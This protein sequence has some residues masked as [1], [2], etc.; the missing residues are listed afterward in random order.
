[1]SRQKTLHDYWSRTWDGVPPLPSHSCDRAHTIIISDSE[2]EQSEA[3]CGPIGGPPPWVAPA[4]FE[5]RMLPART[6]DQALRGTP[7]FD[8]IWLG[9]DLLQQDVT[10]HYDAHMA[11]YEAFPEFEV[12]NY[13]IGQCL[14]SLH[15]TARHQRWHTKDGP[16]AWLLA[17]Y[18]GEDGTAQEHR[19]CNRAT[20]SLDICMSPQHNFLQAC[21]LRNYLIAITL[22]LPGGSELCGFECGPWIWLSRHATQRSKTR[23]LGSATSAT[24][25]RGNRLL[26]R[27][28]LG[29]TLGW[30]LGIGLVLEQPPSSLV[31]EVPWVKALFQMRHFE[32]TRTYQGRFHGRYLKPTRLYSDVPAIRTLTRRLRQGATKR[33]YAKLVSRRGRWTQGLPAALRRS[34]CYPPLFC[35]ALSRC[36]AH[37][38][39]GLD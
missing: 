8:K 17:T 12:A 7:L 29:W 3:V 21:G 23:P 32:T 24:A 27:S 1:M 15:L 13:S 30:S 4:H 37:A 6:T 36:L 20:I 2:A 9:V 5:L 28:Y 18:A 19:R 38:M 31:T 11:L 10:W 33:Q 25:I 26:V 34:A 22:T 39:A 35:R 16:L 14:C